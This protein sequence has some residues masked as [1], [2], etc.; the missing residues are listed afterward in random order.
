MEQDRDFLNTPLFLLEGRYVQI[1]RKKYQS[2]DMN[3]E[4]VIWKR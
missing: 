1:T 2:V 4:I 3:D